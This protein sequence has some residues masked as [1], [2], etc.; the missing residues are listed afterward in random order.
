MK[1]M[2]GIRLRLNQ[3]YSMNRGKKHSERS[4]TSHLLDKRFRRLLPLSVPFLA[5][6]LLESPLLLALVL[7][8]LDFTGLRPRVVVRFFSFLHNP[9]PSFYYCTFKSCSLYQ[10]I[11]LIISRC[12]L[13]CLFANFAVNFVG[14]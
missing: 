9:R 1:L 12:I 2:C 5:V 13:D 4:Q 8:L 11:F 10:I 6:T 3:R 14:L 7:V